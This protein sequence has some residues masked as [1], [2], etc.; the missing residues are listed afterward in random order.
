MPSTVHIHAPQPT[1][2]KARRTTCLDCK[3][4]VVMLAFFTP[5][6]GWDQT[7]T[8]CGRQW[9]DG[10]W[11]QLGFYRTARKDSI[12]GAVERWKRMRCL[13]IEAREKGGGE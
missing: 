4:H 9:H 1:M 10:E 3:R 2:R 13:A 8:K 11:A 6:Y 7:C 12:R 5:W